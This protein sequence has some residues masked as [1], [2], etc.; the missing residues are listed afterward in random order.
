MYPNMDDTMSCFRPCISDQGPANK[1]KR[2]PGI[3]CSDNEKLAYDHRNQPRL[4]ISLAAVEL[5]KILTFK[6]E[7]LTKFEYVNQH[8]FEYR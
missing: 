8:N 7:S 4:L 1:A 3:A 6:A 5:R 2:T